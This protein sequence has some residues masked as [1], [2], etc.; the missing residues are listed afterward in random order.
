MIA[1]LETDTWAGYDPV[2]EHCFGNLNCCNRRVPL[3]YVM[4]AAD[5][6]LANK[7][8]P[9][10]GYEAGTESLAFANKE[11]LIEHAVTVFR[12]HF[13]GAR[14]LVENRNSLYP[15]PV[16]FGPPEVQAAALALHDRMEAQYAGRS[17]P[18]SWAE[19]DA[20]LAEW[21]ALIAPYKAKP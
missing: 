17:E 9:G 2:A 6:A 11:A 20:I 13:P 15:G 10:A 19:H 8:H 12:D 5:A 1:Y 16:L 18:K 3:S 21:E 14:L 4:T 7:K